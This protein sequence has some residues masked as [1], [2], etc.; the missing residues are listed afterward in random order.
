MT[1]SYS[2]ISPAE[3]NARA[4]RLLPADTVVRDSI[5]EVRRRVDAAIPKRWRAAVD[6]AIVPDRKIFDWWDRDVDVLRRLREFECAHGAALNW[7]LDDTEICERAVKIAEHASELTS[8]IDACGSIK[9]VKLSDIQKLEAVLLLCKITGVD[10]PVALTVAGA[11]ARGCSDTW[12]RRA[13]RKKVSRVIEHGAIKLGLVTKWRGG[14][15]SDGAVKR[16][17]EQIARNEA[18]LKKTLIR[19]EAGQVYTLHELA[20]LGVSNRDNRRG[21]LMTRIRGCEEYADSVGHCALFF[22]LTAPSKFHA[23]SFGKHGNLRPNRHYGKLEGDDTDCSPRG[24]QI[25][26]RTMWARARAELHRR[27]VGVYGFRV[28]EPHHDGTPHWHALF[29]FKSESDAAIAET[30]IRETWL[31]EYGDENGALQH[32]VK[33]VAIDRSKGSAAG[34]IAKYITKNVGADFDIETEGHSRKSEYTYK[35]VDAWAATWGIRQFQSVGLPSVTVWRCLRGVDRGQV[36]AA[37]VSGERRDVAACLAYYAAHKSGEVKACFMRY[38]L[39][40]GGVCRSRGEWALQVAK[41]VNPS[42]N[43]YGEAFDK[44]TAVGVIMPSGGWLVSKRIQWARVANDVCDA[45]IAAPVSVEGLAARAALALPWT[46][47]NNCTA[48]LSGDLRRQLFGKNRVLSDSFEVY[49]TPIPL[50]REKSRFMGL[51][52]LP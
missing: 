46:R 33:A 40:M 35:R 22:T 4:A 14:Y 28:A 45:P 27:G 17:A 16:R 15:A 6:D 36:D 1:N 42:I 20:A 49:K 2:G 29:W 7:N 41:R 32:R 21:E 52:D 43:G 3:F 44:K 19:N 50:F 37:R 9:A 18:M 10:S 23:V 51:N 24:A 13:I 12:W 26:L 25:W 11:V 39:A 34:Y 8:D 30:V 31:S 38:M 47:F 48:R 5:R